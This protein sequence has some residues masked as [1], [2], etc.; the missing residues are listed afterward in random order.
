MIPAPRPIACISCLDVSVPASTYRNGICSESYG[1]RER[2][3]ALAPR[4]VTI[5]L[6]IPTAQQLNAPISIAAAAVSLTG[7]LGS[8]SVVAL[9]DMA[10][11]KDLIVRGLAAAGAAHAQGAAALAWK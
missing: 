4:S 3:R 11:Y 5:A 1:P 2:A 9:L 6:A 10:G 8:N 7:L